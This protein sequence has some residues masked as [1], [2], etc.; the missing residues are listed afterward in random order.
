MRA[1]LSSVRASIRFAVYVVGATF[2]VAAACGGTSVKHDEGTP[3]DG[4]GGGT[5][6]IAGSGEAGRDGTPSGGTTGEAGSTGA[7]GGNA[8]GGNAAGGNAAGGN[9]T[10]GT[11]VIGGFAGAMAGFAGSSAGAPDD[12]FLDCLMPI[13]SG[14][15]N[16]AFERFAFN[17]ATL[18]CEPFTW[19]GCGGNENR[20]ESL[21][22]CE[23][24]C[25]DPLP[26]DCTPDS[27]GP[28]CPCGPNVGSCSRTR[29]SSAPYELGYACQ[30]SDAMLCSRGGSKGGCWCPPDSSSR[31]C[32][33]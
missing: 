23:A 10:G 3:G 28:G 5:S 7:L 12:P 18:A 8:T 2:F 24:G 16:A 13:E 1:N 29:C 15:C 20:F 32:G 25:V 17:Q 30:P 6:G 14:N 22:E 26:K 21:E 9:A 27:R 11:I 19:G 4:G 33:V 31:T